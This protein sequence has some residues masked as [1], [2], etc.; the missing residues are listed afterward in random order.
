M[1]DVRKIYVAATSHLT[2]K[3]GEWLNADPPGVC[4]SCPV[5]MGPYEGYGHFFWVPEDEREISSSEMDW[6]SWPG[7][8]AVVRR[9]RALGCDFV[10]LDCDAG[11]DAELPTYEW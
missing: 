5:P 1:H 9:A 8:L 4:A 3:E 10:L 2:K 11:E 7:L 6:V